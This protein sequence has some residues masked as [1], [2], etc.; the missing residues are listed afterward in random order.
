MIWKYNEY[1]TLVDPFPRTT[2]EEV[3]GG[4][5]AGRLYWTEKLLNIKDV[6]GKEFLYYTEDH[7][8]SLP[9]SVISKTWNA[10]VNE[11]VHIDRRLSPRMSTALDIYSRSRRNNGSFVAQYD[12]EKADKNID[13]CSLEGVIPSNNSMEQM[14]SGTLRVE[15]EAT[16]VVSKSRPGDY[17]SC[18]QTIW[19]IRV[20][21]QTRSRGDAEFS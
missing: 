6:V 1:H 17:Q 16:K 18:S 9:D 15:L 12:R 11:N 8:R 7:V 10:F 13:S 21:L 2:Q 19:S 3:E 20:L 4:Y 5:K 14:L